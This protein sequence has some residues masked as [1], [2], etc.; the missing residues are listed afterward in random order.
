M[1]PLR[2]CCSLLLV[3]LLPASAQD[4]VDIPDAALEAAIRAAINKP[5]GDLFPAD[6][7]ALSV[8]ESRRAGIVDLRGLEFATNLHTLRLPDNLIADL[9]PLAGLENL[10]ELDLAE[11]SVADLAPLAGLEGLTQLDLSDNDL[12]DIDSIRFL[13]GLETLVFDH[14]SVFDISALASLASLA[15][16]SADNNEIEDLAPLADLPALQYLNLD[17]N[18]VADLTPLVNLGTLVALSLWDNDLEDLAGIEGLA[19]LQELNLDANSVEDLSPLAGLTRLANLSIVNNEV[20]NLGPLEGSSALRELDITNNSVENLSPLSALTGLVTLRARNNDIVNIGPLRQLTSLEVLDLSINEIQSILPLHELTRLREL[21]LWDNDISNLWPLRALARLEQLNLDANDIERIGALADLRSLQSL[22]LWRNFVTDLRPLCGLTALRHLNVSQN[23]V[24]EID[25]LAGLAN[26]ETLVLHH[27]QIS[28]FGP[29]RRLNQLREANLSWNSASRAAALVELPAVARVDLSDNPLSQQALC[30]DI[31]LLEQRGVAVAYDGVCLS[32]SR[33]DE[34]EDSL[35]DQEETSVHGTDPGN[36]DTDGDGIPDGFEA[37]NGLDPRIDDA[38]ADADGDG[39]KDLYEYFAKADPRDAASPGPVFY[40]GPAGQNRDGFGF[41]EDR[42]WQTISFAIAE[43]GPRLAAS[44]PRTLLLLPGV[45]QEDKSVRLA[46]WMSVV[47]LSREEVIIGDPLVAA[48][49]AALRNCTLSPVSDFDAVSLLIDYASMTVDSVIFAGPVAY[50]GIMLEASLSEEIVIDACEFRGLANGLV[51]AG[52]NPLI[53]RCEFARIIGDAIRIDRSPAA[54]QAELELGDAGN[55]NTGF[56]TFE[57]IGGAAVNNEGETAVRLERNYLAPGAA[58]E[59]DVRVEA[60]L[61]EKMLPAAIY[62]TV[63]DAA[64]KTRLDEATVTLNDTATLSAGQDGVYAF[65]CL[66]AGLH[67]IAVEMT[68]YA[69]ESQQVALDAG[70]TRSLVFSMTSS[71]SPPPPLCFR[72]AT[73]P[74]SQR[75]VPP[76]LLTALLVVM[77]LEWARRATR[78]RRI[79]PSAAPRNC[80]LQKA[81]AC[82]V[83]WAC[84]QKVDAR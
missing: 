73:V 49:H 26:L 38:S 52:A 76:L 61:G 14:N 1:N 63:W 82:P 23:D 22:T 6:L 44:Q 2:A 34:D 25:A 57:D 5:T 8:L 7:A 74:I 47:G 67:E 58:L 9:A 69:P 33:E 13:T 55:L 46:P 79:P 29:L 30:G 17:Q 15:I 53:R 11:N 60:G 62:C 45:Y 75:G 50:T 37:R 39:L 68:G 27:N 41:S 51:L 21:F 83:V 31:D 56:N 36:P 64:A 18:S 81:D 32:G 54:K 66:E 12:E 48:R 78:R 19:G 4:T 16:F 42:P 35:P 65:V 71:G 70:M 80:C 59:G 84:D 72:S 24:E 10:R 77:G 43:I 20:E 28:D 40:V 3:A